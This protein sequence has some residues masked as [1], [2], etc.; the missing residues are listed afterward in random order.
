MVQGVREIIVDRSL[1]MGSGSCSFHAPATFDLDDAGGVI[2]LGG[3]DGDAQIR[4]AIEGCP[5]GAIRLS[6]RQEED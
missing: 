4:A 1:C 3:R 2:L 6:D 5:T